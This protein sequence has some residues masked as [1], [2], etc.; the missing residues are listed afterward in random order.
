VNLPT[1]KESHPD[2][3]SGWLESAWH[4]LQLLRLNFD[5]PY[6]KMGHP[7]KPESY[8]PEAAY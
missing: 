7:V 8:L 6:M 4:N 5:G 3:R 1:K 2:N